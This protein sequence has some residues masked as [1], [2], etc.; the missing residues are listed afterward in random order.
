MTR[1]DTRVPVIF[2]DGTDLDAW[3]VEAG[4]GAPDGVAAAEFAL[5]AAIEP[6]HLAGCACCQPQGPIA[7]ALRGLFIA[8]AKASIPFFRRIAVRA[9]PRG[10]DAVRAT[11]ANDPLCAAWFRLVQCG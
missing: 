3:L 4:A 6:Y 10:E 11:L 7:L 5:P 2:G 9:T 1:I 8:R